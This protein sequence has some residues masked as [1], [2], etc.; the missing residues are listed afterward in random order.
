VQGIRRTAV[1]LALTVAASL[2][3]CTATDASPSDSVSGTPAP[4]VDVAPA[5]ATTGAAMTF[6]LARVKA[7]L[8]GV[9]VHG[10]DPYNDYD[11]VA[12]FGE[13]WVDVDR[14]GCDTR[15]DI[16][17]R[18]L[19]EVQISGRCTVDSGVLHDPYTG[20]TVDYERGPTTSEAVQIDHVVPVY[21]AWRTGAQ[22]WTTD[23]RVAF[24]NDP[25]NLLAVSGEANQDKGDLY[26][27]RWLPHRAAYRCPYVERYVTVVAKYGLHLTSGDAQAIRRVLD[28]CPAS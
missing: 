10:V 5:D 17:R 19:V 28:A 20:R 12:D 13:S 22:A 25:L 27:S 2:A 8:A 21:E 23:R 3:G 7:E 26:P 18:D 1:A 16:L 15:S 24:A 9:V 4:T 6:D 11:R 14:N